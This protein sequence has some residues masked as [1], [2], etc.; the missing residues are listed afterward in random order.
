M[1]PDWG[2][3]SV[4]QRLVHLSLVIKDEQEFG[5]QKKGKE[6]LCFSFRLYKHT[7]CRKGS[8]WD[9]KWR[10]SCGIPS[11]MSLERACEL[12]GGMGCGE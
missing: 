1:S 8:I 6:M 5:G 9:A 2:N 12:Y 4:S 11:L 7:Q 3:E 10:Y